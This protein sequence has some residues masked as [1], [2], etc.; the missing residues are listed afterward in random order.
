MTDENT[1]CQCGANRNEESTKSSCCQE[2]PATGTSSAPHKSNGST[3]EFVSIGAPREH[4]LSSADSKPSKG[5][6]SKELSSA[7]RSESFLAVAIAIALFVAFLSGFAIGGNHAHA[8]D[9]LARFD[10]LAMQER[11][12]GS[13]PVDAFACS[14]FSQDE[15]Y[16]G[17]DYVILPFTGDDNGVMFPDTNDAIGI[18]MS[19]GRGQ[20]M[21]GAMGGSRGGAMSGAGSTMGSIG[22]AVGTI[23]STTKA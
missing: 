4:S 19:E 3:L 5:F 22:K 13:Q 17:G 11:M 10:H 1:N 21:G 23:G 2:T 15:V 18:D 9:R 14:T 12:F 8:M 16:L 6:L 7:D 20:S